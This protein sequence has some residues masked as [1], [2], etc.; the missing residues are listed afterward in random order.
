MT[1]IVCDLDGVIWRGRE[2]IAGSDAAVAQLREAGRRV[3]FVT[4]NSAG[5][6]DDVLAH[7]EACGIP[8]TP[9]DIITSA[10]AA[11][12]LLRVMLPPD[13]P[14]YA[15]AGPGVIAA[16]RN[17][18][19]EPVGTGDADRAEA[20]V[21][22]WHRTF[23]FARLDAAARVARAGHLFVATNVDPT[24]PAEGGTLLPGS[25]SIVAAV[26]TAAGLHPLVAGKPEGPTVDL[27]HARFGVDGIM[28]GDRPSTDGLLAE[29]LGWPFA[30]VR[31]GIAGEGP[32][33]EPIPDPAPP[34]LGDD[35]AAIVDALLAA[36]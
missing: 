21:V 22:G 16:L 10:D 29:R 11:A 7:L 14:V 12:A 4:N 23:D 6:V 15:C 28:V 31:T 35:F 34:I 19:L 9:D 25:G 2:P 18:G 30:L 13:T 20:V 32:G 27:V 26:A 17:A 33:R 1:S 3:G 8:A 24:Y 36:S 5:T